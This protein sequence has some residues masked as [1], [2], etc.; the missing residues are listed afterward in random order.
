MAITFLQGTLNPASTQKAKDLRQA[1][2]AA[3]T[4]ITGWTI[5]DDGYVNGTSERAV[6]VN[7]AGFA[8]MLWHST[9]YSTLALNIVFGQSYD[10]GTHTMNNI[11]LGG[12]FATAKTINATGFSGVS[13][14]PTGANTIDIIH[15]TKTITPTASQTNWAASIDSTY[16]ILSFKDGSATSGKAMY[17]GE[18]NN[19]MLN[20]ALTNVYPYGVLF[21]DGT[22]GINL[23]SSGNGSITLQAV[24]YSP[25]TFSMNHAGAPASIGFADIYG[26]Y[27]DLARVAPVFVARRQKN[28]NGISA[29][30]YGWLQGTLKSVYYAHPSNAN[31]GDTV[32]I[33]SKTYYYSGGL[34]QTAWWVER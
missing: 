9:N 26:L 20:T 34:Y 21:S 19:L 11:G 17:V 13:Y 6:L 25:I 29:N 30:T 18:Y 23:N 10:S 27:P 5:V 1:W 22:R 33:D 24:E 12:V 14:N 28:P 15:A 8:L 7:S 4:G 2:V 3:F 32:T 16:A 31:W